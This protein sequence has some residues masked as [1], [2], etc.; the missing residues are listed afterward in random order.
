MLKSTSCLATLLAASLITACSGGSSLQDSLQ[1]P[2]GGAVIYSSAGAEGPVAST[3]TVTAEP[4]P[5]EMQPSDADT[6]RFLA[7]AS[8]GPVGYDEVSAV[9]RIGFDAWINH[10]MELAAPSHLQ[11]VIEQSPRDSNG[12]PQHRMSYEAVWQQWLFSEAQLRARVAFAL[13][14]IFVVSNSAG[15]LHPTGLSSYMDMLNRNAFGNYRSLLE[16]VSLH[17][18]MGY[19]L[20]MIESEKEDPFKGTHPN[21]N[22]AREVLQ[23]FSIGLHHLNA[24]GTPAVDAVGDLIPAYD[25]DVVQGFAR[26]FSGWSFGNRDTADTRAFGRGEEDWTVPMKPWASH[27]STSEKHLLNG[28]VLPAGQTPQ[29][30]LRLALDSIFYHPNVGP[31]ISRRLIQ[32]LVTSNPSPAYILRITTIFNDNG[33]GVRGDLAAIVKAILL[34]EEARTP[35]TSQA[36]SAG[37]QREPV[38]RFANILRAMNAR[39]QSGHSDIQY[40]NSADNGL[41]QSPLLAPSVFNFYS[42]DYRSPGPIAAAGLTAPEFQITTETAVVGTLNFFARLI[43]SG[44]YGKDQNRLNLDFDSLT[45]PAGD[46]NWLIDHMVLMFM[47]GQVSPETRVAMLRA[48]NSI[49]PSNTEERIKTALILTAIAPEFVVQ[50]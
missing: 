19:F 40:L 18:A 4:L 13:S 21:E 28:L 20:N 25:Q 15:D 26:A 17:P 27:H 39:S 33:A 8:F 48:I 22:Y 43:E 45:V 16:E 42:P 47:N 46:A 2:A 1:G 35:M 11:Y 32:R 49:D 41:G 44:G 14:Q 34:D 7:Q 23:L 31:F 12:R 36:A 37:K 9:Q 6:V 5:A 10:Q 50:R 3:K 29:E 38:I 24:D 30:D